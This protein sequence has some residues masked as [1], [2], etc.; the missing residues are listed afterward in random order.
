M[1]NKDSGADEAA[2]VR[3]IRVSL[4]GAKI[5]V[6]DRPPVGN[7][8]AAL[9]ALFSERM[10]AEIITRDEEGEHTRTQQV[11]ALP[12]SINTRLQDRYEKEA[13]WRD[14]RLAMLR[15]EAREELAAVKTDKHASR[16][17]AKINDE[18]YAVY[19]PRLTKKISFR[20]IGEF[21]RHFE[22]VD[23]YATALL[24]NGTWELLANRID[25]LRAASAGRG[26][27]GEKMAASL[28]AAL[29][30]L[31]GTYR[32]YIA[33]VEK[34]G[35]WEKLKPIAGIVEKALTSARQLKGFAQNSRKEL[36]ETLPSEHVKPAGAA[37]EALAGLSKDLAALHGSCGT[38]FNAVAY[39][40]AAR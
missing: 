7:R 3:K 25:Q 8:I 27:E 38:L 28:S 15:S 12:H 20:T 33:I 2:G 31:V 40:S 17:E 18:T 37:L 30:Q 39:K 24:E 22:N 34:T 1:T 35:Q 6:M 29:G 10:E 19:Y 36:L 21:K 26:D 32:P 23:N 9:Q 14:A 4:G 11:R 16:R 5:S 13:P